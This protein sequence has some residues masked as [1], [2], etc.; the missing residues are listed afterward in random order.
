[1]QYENLEN[2]PKKK[3]RAE[4]C[5]YCSKNHDGPCL[6]KL[7]A[8]YQCGKWGHLSGECSSKKTNDSKSISL[9]E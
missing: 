1:M 5:G 9:V 7:G 3:M 4:T 8:C 6:K 2:N